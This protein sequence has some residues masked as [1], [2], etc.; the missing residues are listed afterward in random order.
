MINIVST[1]SSSPESREQENVDFLEKRGIT[2]DF[3]FKEKILPEWANFDEF[4]SDMREVEGRSSEMGVEL[5]W[6]GENNGAMAYVAPSESSGKIFFNLRTLVF[7]SHHRGTLAHEFTHL[8]QQWVTGNAYT[9]PWLDK[10]SDITRQTL[11]KKAGMTNMSVRDVLEWFVEW[12]TAVKHGKNE[13]VAY[14]H[15]QVPEVKKLNAFVLEKTGVSLIACYVQMTAESMSRFETALHQASNEVMLEEAA[16]N[17][18]WKSLSIKQ[19]NHI[20][21]MARYIHER[22]DIIENKI[23]AW[24]LALSTRV[25]ETFILQW[26]VSERVASSLSETPKYNFWVSDVA[27]ENVWVNIFWDVIYVT[28]DKVVHF[29]THDRHAAEFHELGFAA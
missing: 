17:I 24:N 20:N 9:P 19:K 23:E 28:A 11:Y 15:L 18:S 10:I 6:V 29:L 26:S 1:L 2:P 14:T 13:N 27:E 21:S 25:P 4:V 3:L 8:K 5:Q 16:E 22:G 12:S 7:D